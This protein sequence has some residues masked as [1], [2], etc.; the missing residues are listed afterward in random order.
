MDRDEIAHVLGHRERAGARHPDR[1]RRR[2]R[3]QARRLGAAAARRSRPGSS[4][5][6][7]AAPSPGRRAWRRPP[8]AIRR[9]CAQGPPVARTARSPRSSST[10]TSIPAPTHP[11]DRPS[12]AGC[13]STPPGPTPCPTSGTAA[14]P[15]TPMRRRPER[16]AASACRNAPSR[17]RRCTT[18]WPRNAASTRS[19]SG[20]ATRCA[21]ATR[22]QPARCSRRAR[23]LPQC[24]EALEPALAPG[25]PRGRSLQRPGR[26]VAAR[27]RHRLHVVRLRQH[28]AVQPVDHARRHQPRRAGLTLYNGAVDMGQ[29]PNTIMVQICADALGVPAGRFE[30][31]MGDTALTADAGKSSASRQTFVSGKAAAARRG[32]SARATPAPGQCRR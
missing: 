13:R 18:S 22:R 25:A 3:R 12:P 11:G 32:G 5:G 17:T 6:R 23:G 21:R 24:L 7:C 10:A 1:V 16:S 19:S 27:R 30:V 14:W 9:G 26:A 29:G 4:A 2:L 31:V 20:C 8:S 15:C 28:L